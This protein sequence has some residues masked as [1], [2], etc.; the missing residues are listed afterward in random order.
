M[1]TRTTFVKSVAILLFWVL[2]LPCKATS[3]TFTGSGD[4]GST[5]NWSGDVMPPQVLPFGDSIVINGTGTCTFNDPYEGN[6]MQIMGTF[7]VSAGKTLT[8]N[9]G[10]MRIEAAQ[11]N[12]YGTV[13]CN[14]GTSIDYDNG[15]VNVYGT[16][17]VNEMDGLYS[18]NNGALNVHS[19]GAI[20]AN[21]GS[22]NIRGSGSIAAG[23]TMAT[24][25]SG[26]LDGYWGTL[27][28]Y[29][30][31]SNSAS[32]TIHLEYG[33]INNLGTFTNNGEITRWVG[34]V[35]G[36]G[37]I[38]G[39][40]SFSLPYTNAVGATLSPGNSPGCTVFDGDFVN[41]GT[42]DIELAD[43]S[44]CTNF[45]QIQV[46]NGHSAT[47]GGIINITFP[48]GVPSTTVFA[49]LTATGTKTDNS[50]TINWPAGYTG[51]GS[52]VG[53]EYRVS[54]SPL[55]VD[56]VEFKGKVTEGNQ[57]RLIWKTASEVNNAGFIVE[58]SWDLRAWEPLDQIA[59]QGNSL[60]GKDYTCLDKTPLAG[61]NY[62]RLKQ[63]DLDGKHSYS[64]VLTVELP[65]ER[66]AALHC[67]PNP[68]YNHVRLM[69]KTAAVGA[70]KLQLFHST[71]FIVREQA[72][73]LNGG[74][75][76][77]DLDI[78]QLPPGIYTIKLTIGNQVLQR[79]LM[80]A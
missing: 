12:V 80:I 18:S 70:G 3:Y 4:W 15:T 68:A 21:G 40:G 75:L 47:I 63:M 65:L 39:S 33:V 43:G 66:D 52:F 6:L 73:Y 51:S 46:I 13:N 78:Q 35:T 76:D 30:T 56:L 38:N 26:R 77:H 32:G 23:G 48:S 69:A 79:R 62:Y 19:G 8:M 5:S 17:N 61:I 60:V 64:N 72:I 45:D 16:I 25:G 59:G 55:P 67:W 24:L 37:M 11:F 58:R 34:S 41:N 14:Y 49:I 44:S 7:V 22:F 2:A 42:L 20:Y 36:T 28:N 31:L 54:F 9:N 29:G 71:G 50:P 10:T 74:G 57:V 27:T 1:D 53:N